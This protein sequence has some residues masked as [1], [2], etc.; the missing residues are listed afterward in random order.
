[1]EKKNKKSKWRAIRRVIL[2]VTLAVIAFLVFFAVDVFDM[3]EWHDFEPELILDSKKSLMVYDKNGGEAS[4]LYSKENRQWIGID[5]IPMHVRYAFISAED[6]RFYE[7]GGVDIIRIF[8]AA[9]HDLKVGSLEQGASTI[10]QQLI[11]LSHLTTEEEKPEKTMARKLEEAVLACK[12]ERQFD[13]DEILEMYLNYVYFGAGYYGVEAAARGYFGVHANELTVAQAAML[14][15]ILKSPSN[16]APHLN[17]EKSLNRRNL[18]LSLMRDYGYISED[19]YTKYREEP[20]TLSTATNRNVRNYYID[21]AIEEA[22]SILNVN[23]ETLLTGGYKIYTAMDSGLQEYCAQLM[24]NEELFPAEDVQGAIV[25]VDVNTRMVAAVMGGREYDVAHGFNRAT[26]IRR[27]PGSVIKPIIS[28]APALEYHGY[29]AATMILDEPTSFGDYEPGNAGGK[30]YGWVTMRE[31]VK[32]SLNV[33]A[34]KVLS[35]VSVSGGKLFAQRL[36]IE[37]DEADGGLALALGGFTYGVSPLQLAGAYACFASGGYYDAPA[38]ITKITDSSGE[39]LYERES[40]MIRVMSEEN[41]YNRYTYLKSAVLE[42]TGHRLSALEMPIAG[43]TGTVGDSSST[44][45]AW[46]AAYNPEYTATVWIGYDKDEDGKKLPSDATGGSYPALILY[47]LFKYLYPNGSEIDFAMPKGVKEYRLDG[48]TLANS[49]SAVLATALTPSNMVVKEVF[50]EGTEPGIRSEYWSLPAPPNDIKG[51]LANGLPRI[52]FTPLK[53]H[54]L[55]RLF[56]QDNYGSVV[57]IGEWSGNT[58]R[59]TYADTSAEHGMRYA[60]YIVPVHPE[61]IIDGKP[62]EGIK[63]KSVTIQTDQSFVPPV[64][65]PNYTDDPEYTTPDPSIPTDDSGETDNPPRPT[66]GGEA[67]ILPF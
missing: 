6:A 40:S 43:K 25:V 27:Q 14:A 28:Y 53:S 61:I 7:H 51:E 32:R 29:T 35:D 36:G 54:I 58:N 67:F 16:Y 30:Y 20:V 22:C 21:M 31:A 48:Y 56:R 66:P 41:S 34:V 49:H 50:A 4:L 12:M 8:G 52:S 64:D 55:Y 47:E 17:M 39:T 15:G 10:S 18:V 60:Y 3:D 59:V 2:G 23:T 42:G 9:L 5:E 26:D 63:S 38:L 19:E 65:I 37:F 62:V 13:K 57:L 33:P 24:K 44:R 11:K 46:M 1:M 45:D